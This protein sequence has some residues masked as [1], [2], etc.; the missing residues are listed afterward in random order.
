LTQVQRGEIQP[1]L[2]QQMSAKMVRFSDVNEFVYDSDINSKVWCSVDSQVSCDS[3]IKFVDDS[4]WT[5]GDGVC[6]L[7]LD[8]LTCDYQMYAWKAWELQKLSLQ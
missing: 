2:P 6:T 4:A 3:K 1:L 7:N 5:I 8:W